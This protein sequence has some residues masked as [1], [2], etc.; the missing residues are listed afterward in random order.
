MAVSAHKQRDITATTKEFR[1]QIEGST[2][3]FYTR[4]AGS[5]LANEHRGEF[6]ECIPLNGDE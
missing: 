5:S 6:R 4:V 1:F 2:I 3:V